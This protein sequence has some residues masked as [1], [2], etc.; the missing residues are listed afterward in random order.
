MM[1][2]IIADLRAHI[3]S[4]IHFQPGGAG[5]CI[6]PAPTR[7]AIARSG[8]SLSGTI[9]IAEYVPDLALVRRAAMRYY[10]I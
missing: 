1:G 7:R 8:G 5:E 9:G 2:R 3:Y 10:R 6:D 4:F